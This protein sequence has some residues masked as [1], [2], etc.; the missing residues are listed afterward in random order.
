VV[1]RSQSQQLRLVGRT[2]DLAAV[3]A[4]IRAA[5]ANRAGA[6]LISGE[7]GV[8]KT[9]LARAA[10][11][12]TES[13]VDVLWAS[14]LPLTSL[15]VPFLPL[16][17]ALRDWAAGHAE[18]VPLLRP[19]GETGSKDGPFEFDGWLAGLGERRPVVLVVDDLH[20][21]DESTLDVLMYVL[22][23]L[24]DHRL[25]V[26]AM[27]RSGEVT[28]NHPLRRWLADVRRFPGVSELRLD[29][30]DRAA[31][32]EQMTVLLGG[33]AHEA[34]V[35][36]I[37]ARTDGNAYLT[38]LLARGL[39]LDARSLPA[40]LP[41]EL[42]DAATRAW[43]SLTSPTR[44]L[45]RLIAVAGRPQRSDQL[46]RLAALT[47]LT[48]DVVLLLRE[49]VDGAVLHLGASETYWFVHP[50]LAEVLEAG[51]LPEERRALH[52]AFVEALDGQSVRAD[53]LDV[54]RV[55]DLADH[56]Y[57]AGHRDEAY[58][59]AVLGSEAAGRAGGAKEMLRLL[60]RAFDLWPEVA[61]AEPDRHDLLQRIRLAADQA[62]AQEE[63]LI[64]VDDLLEPVDRERD[65]LT[66]AELLVR[67]MILRWST[68][69]EFAPMA[70]VGE[71]VRLSA[72]TPDSWQYALAM[73]EL[74]DAELWH[75]VPSGAARAEE[76]VRL[77]RACGSKK[78][79]AH[80]LT[81]RVMSR[82]M[83]FE[84]E[85]LTDPQIDA[86]EAQ[87][88][89][90]E[91]RD[92]Y[93]YSHATLWASNLIDGLASRPSNDVVRRG[94]EHLISL[95][96]PHTYVSWL[97]A[98]EAIGLLALGDWRACA[99]RLRY[100]LGSTPGPMGAAETRLDAALL[101]GWQG[102]PAEAK[103]HLARADELFAEQS[104]FRGLLFDAVRA[105]VALS[106]GDT[107]GAIAAAMAGVEGEGVPPRLSERLLPLA[108]RAIAD[109]AQTSRDRGEDPGQA[110]ARMSSL[111]RRYPEV[112]GTPQAYGPM[113]QLQLRAMQALYDAEVLR[114]K[115]DPTAS[116]VW[117]PAAEACRDAELAWDE[118]YARRRAAEALLQDRATHQQG[119]VEL[120]RAHEL[121]TDLEA[122]PQLVELRA[123]ARTARV[124]LTDPRKVPAEMVNGIPG[125]TI[126]E[127]EILTHLVAGRT[128]SE[129]ARELVISEKTVSVHVS[130]LLHK[131]GTAN[132]VELAGLARRTGVVATD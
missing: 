46:G 97:A 87:V 39:P 56:H 107:E 17:T 34:L 4:L 5:A 85:E 22:A 54:E 38:T 41:T 112:I 122:A 1:V 103:A 123:L 16:T 9:A 108:A 77:A 131:T 14:C 12:R 51:L 47:G 7:A 68:G 67:R 106:A 26:L 49:A 121:A 69:R 116:A 35:D 58:R 23:G 24:A 25:A 37:Y 128:Y 82:C 11:S 10:C 110:V 74:A 27:I 100:A 119:V 83:A 45:T 101:A 53:P 79:L 98:H 114:G 64:A 57:R 105:E 94:R 18:P 15:A 8:G 21:A 80:A 48:G 89:A 93:A 60:R 50:L 95:G 99:E 72:N 117:R 88:A 102:R 129:I 127:R 32:G 96:A 59:W 62:G 13:T 125:L 70:D 90:A 61:N 109:Q 76:A 104:G 33:P 118:A 73:A 71:A 78:A 66:A 130:N 92:F 43:R 31:T 124:R 42:G 55:V 65:P 36:Q 19:S 86:Q 126:R 63:E 120:R 29:R 91:V 3:S 40:G 6:L 84:G 132:R 30:L 20:W 2:D 28:E 44:A 115:A 113:Y 111:Y 52:G 81:A 75:E